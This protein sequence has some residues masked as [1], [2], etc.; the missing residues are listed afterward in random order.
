[1]PARRCHLVSMPAFKDMQMSLPELQDLVVAQYQ[2]I[3][4]LEALVL[5]LK[6]EI[7]SLRR[8][9]KRQA[10]P[11]SKGE[12]K[13]N[14]KKPGR[15]P[16]SDPSGS[17][18]FSYRAAPSPEE[19]TGPVVEVPLEEECC[20]DCG[21]TLEVQES[22]LATNTDIPV[23]IK[24]VVR[25][26]RVAVCRCVECGRSVRGRHPDLAPSQYG[27]T[28]HR[29]EPRVMA[30]AHTLHF[31]CGVPVCK[32]PFILKEMCGIRLSQSAITQDGKRRLAGNLGTLHQELRASIEKSRKVHTDDT[33]W[34]IGGESAHLM[35]FDTDEASVYQIRRQHRNEEVRELVPATYP[36][37]MCTDRGKS[38]DAKE[39][40]EVKQNKC[41]GHIQRSID[42]VLE[43]KVGKAQ[44]AHREFGET[45]KALL[46]EAV[47]LWHFYHQGPK[48]GAMGLLHQV[49]YRSKV[50]R[51]SGRIT[52]HLRARDL[53]DP[54]NQRLLNQLSWH[55][56][57]GNVLRFL[58]DPSLE[59]TNNRAERA[60]RPAVIARK[61]SQCSKTDGGAEVFSAFTT[62]IQTMK[63]S[64]THSLV[65]GLAHVFQTGALPDA[66]PP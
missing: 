26:Y 44:E 1:M 57:R 66:L 65:D 53:K 56:S 16:R 43:K 41:T 4:E 62:V 18:N 35:V 6:E 52:H 34:R 32:V 55:H 19:F 36:G 11:F 39:F 29:I 13:A 31:G 37:T 21:G 28:A 2:K 58:H 46:K 54:D 25:A 61:V 12:R 22:E 42:A 20:P 17:N 49:R 40:S 23:I 50:C 47:Q 38:Y 64:G 27:T 30:A 10:A 5:A 59:P 24:P 60:L 33:G 51:L 3:Q 9:G 7:E 15:K 14:P 48:C 8:G 63:K 45:L